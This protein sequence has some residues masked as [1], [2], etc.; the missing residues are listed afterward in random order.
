MCPHDFVRGSRG[1]P[2][3]AIRRA[4]RS[5]TRDGAVAAIGVI[6]KTGSRGLGDP[7]LQ[8]CALPWKDAAPRASPPAD[9]S[10]VPP[11]D[12]NCM[13]AKILPCARLCLAVAYTVGL[14]I[15][16]AAEQVRPEDQISDLVQHGDYAVA[17]Q[18]AEALTRER[19]SDARAQA[20]HREAS[21][22]Y[23]LEQGRRLTFKDQDV[24]ALA[25]F[26]E[27]QRIEPKA[28]EI[29]AW[30]DKT[31]RKL[32]DTWVERG[33]ELHAKQ[34]LAAAVDAYEQA[35]VYMPGDRSALNGLA[36]AVFHINFRNGL[37]EKYFKEG[38]QALSRYWLEQALSRFSYSVK[39]EPNDARTVARKGQVE[40]L[41]AAQRVT[42]A[43]KLEELERFDAARNEFRLALALDPDNTD[44]KAGKERCEKEAQAA[45]RRR[46]AHTAVLRGRFDDADKLLAE[47]AVLSTLQADRFR[48]AREELQ[49]ARYEKVYLDGLALERD[50]L[51][52]EAVAKYAELLTMTEYYKDVLTRKETL[53]GYIGLAGELYD[54]AQAATSPADKQ[55]FLE[56]IELFWAEYKDVRVQLEALK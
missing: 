26:D 42:V 16:C 47:G 11:H 15:G 35:L 21:V 24:E 56:Q 43:G 34:D 2:T 45:A 9:M 33:L 36:T 3:L 12:T 46:E 31:K 14:C 6:G 8:E 54:K 37:S 1:P 49:N 32:A 38:L 4:S 52:P 28:P 55:K 41:L 53:E 20:L 23:L 39:Y 22:A 25:R 19:P 7:A 30:I 51:F 29:T 13:P 48:S 40:T 10:A 17:V 44:A 5:A 27:A 50:M 18:K